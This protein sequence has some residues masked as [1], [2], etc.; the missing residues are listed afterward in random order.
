MVGSFGVGPEVRTGAGVVRG[1]WEAGQA[2][3]R[4]ISFAQPPVGALRFQAPRP[5]QR[6]DGVRPWI[7]WGAPRTPVNRVRRPPA[8]AQLA[9]GVTSGRRRRLVDAQRLD[10]GSGRRA[11]GHGVDP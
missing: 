3:F 4:G 10:T 9:R 1:S 11:P 5:V 6:W 8:A 7:A 2:V